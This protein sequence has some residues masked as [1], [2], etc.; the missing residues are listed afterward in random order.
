[1]ANAI[2]SRAMKSFEEATDDNTLGAVFLGVIGSGVLFGVTC[3]QVYIYYHRFLKDSALHKILVAV[4]WILDALHLALTVHVVYHYLVSNFGN[5]AEYPNIIWSLKLQV[6]VNVVIILIVQSLYAYRV[7]LLGGYHHGILGYLVASVVAGGFAHWACAAIGIILA[8]QVYSVDTFAKLEDIAWAINASLA[9]S[10]TIDF[11]I[12]S[13][14]C[15]YLWK[16]KCNDSR[17]RLNSRISTVMQYTLCSGLLTS[18]CSL[19]TL[20]TYNLMPNNFIFLGL[21]FLLTKLYVGSF[22]AMLNA[23]KSRHRK[24]KNE[25]AEDDS[26]SLAFRNLNF[27]IQTTIQT[28]THR[29][30]YVPSS[31]STSQSGDSTYV[32]FD[33]RAKNW[34]IE[35]QTLPLEEA[36]LPGRQC[37]VVAQ[38]K[39]RPDYMAQW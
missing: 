17:S 36:V 5:H 10:T 15:Y 27:K 31:A 24:C 19:S 7:W 29:G 32:S 39:Q 16:S 25:T 22:L 20:F 14:M 21:E 18:A 6:A 37:T 2:S 23:R 26:S 30:S 38:Q 33:D 13:A 1:M 11:L 8:Y 35:S 34:D 28:E 12:S 9:T 3:L 4:L